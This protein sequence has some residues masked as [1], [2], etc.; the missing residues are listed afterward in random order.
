MEIVRM[1]NKAYRRRRRQQRW[2][3]KA[4]DKLIKF[5][6]T[7]LYQSNQFG[8][9]FSLSVLPIICL[10]CS[11]DY[12]RLQ[13]VCVRR[14][15][16]ALPNV[17]K[18]RNRFHRYASVWTMYIVHL[19]IEVRHGCCWCCLSVLNWGVESWAMSIVLSCRKSKLFCVGESSTRI[20]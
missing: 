8:F 7:S 18:Y 1:W 12:M 9:T 17:A 14:C 3:T 16:L 2:S 5:S 10:S 13:C 11:F 19:H 20:E 6:H 4:M 15:A